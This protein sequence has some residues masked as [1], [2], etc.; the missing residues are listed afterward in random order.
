MARALET[1]D[2][3]AASAFAAHRA[4]A[5]KHTGDG[6]MAVFSS[7]DAAIGA[8]RDLS[9]AIQ[10]ASWPIDEP[11]RLRMGIHVGPAEHRDGDYFGTA[12]SKTARIA[13]A[14]Q[15]GQ[16]L[17]SRAAELAAREISP[18]HRSTDVGSIRLK[19]IEEP[20]H[21]FHLD[22][23][24]FGPAEP[25][26]SGTAPARGLPAV[27]GD[28][29]GRDQ[30][31]DEVTAL[32]EAHR[33]VTLAGVGGVGK[34]RLALAAA[35][36]VPAEPVFVDLAPV[37]PSDV[38]AAFSEALGV[39][40]SGRG[41]VSVMVAALTGRQVIVVADNCE[42]VID[43]AAATIEAL[44]SGSGTVT[45]L[46]TSREPLGLAVEHVYRVPSLDLDSAVLLFSQRAEATGRP[47]TELAG[48]IEVCRRLD[49]IPLA[50]ELAAA[51]TAHLGLDELAARLD[52]RF[53]LLAGG[54]RG[55]ERHRT[56]EAVMSWSYDLLDAS[57]RRALWVAS[58][59][60]GSFDL[61]AFAAVGGFDE[62]DALERLG[63]LIDKSLATVPPGRGTGTRYGLL[64]TVR[65]YGAM[66]ATEG[67]EAEALRDAH[68]RYFRDL[69]GPLVA[70]DLHS[71]WEAYGDRA[72]IES[73]DVVAAL[74]W[75]GATG[76]LA[77][78]GRTAAGAL[79]GLGIDISDRECRFF[80]RDDVVAS[81][82]GSER[83][84]YLVAASTNANY[85][86][87]WDSQARFS[88]LALDGATHAGLKA[89]ATGLY[90]QMA[91]LH[92]EPVD[93]LIADALDHLEPSQGRLA[94]FL[95]GRLLDGP[96]GR[97]EAATVVDQ[98]EELADAGEFVAL[99]DLPKVYVILNRPADAVE[100][101]G[102]ATATWGPYSVWEHLVRAHILAASDRVAAIKQLLT[103]D[104]I[105]RRHYDPLVEAEF[106]IGAAAVAH[107]DGDDRRA[108]WLLAASGQSF[109]T[110]G[111]YAL[112]AHVRNR[113][114]SRID[115][116]AV[117]EARRESASIRPHA[118]W[119]EEL[120]RLQQKIADA[121]G[122]A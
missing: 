84:A 73:D 63:S 30:E 29:I 43:E 1:H 19:G 45:V 58:T 122:E 81:L 9:R 75:F 87:A 61:S 36:R 40:T 86:G 74:E 90:A 54:R 57:D 27:G 14:A 117:D 112:Y 62:L 21:V 82:E 88:R 7:V 101:A 93:R 3:L 26:R 37:G 51:R 80:E 18:S 98:V 55:L 114:R 17:L 13:D 49:G 106:L 119:V 23:D 104:S 89:M 76:D 70:W 91:T 38:V 103:G 94:A 42:H 67:G 50:I 12:V 79:L 72:P 105:L 115:R 56:L 11:L 107:E 85:R 25:P 33:V 41:E 113:V 96:L 22:G 83:D 44:V 64:E 92:G 109:R 28:L 35:S 10:G 99:A 111:G 66:K 78:L 15:T 2:E 121:R 53:R 5:T 68:A 20:E 6:S 100:A 102:R 65:L 71:P 16:V 24:P 34:T 120:L 46:A 69:A 95:R 8:A 31:I 60:R 32:A 116:S 110:P 4:V 77:S 39:G 59:F 108:A 52:E 47:I 118:A 48:V 97:G